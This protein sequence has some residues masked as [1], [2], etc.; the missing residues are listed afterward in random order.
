MMKLKLFVYLL[1]GYFAS[2]NF[3]ALAQDEGLY[4]APPPADAAFVRIVH[5]APD[6]ESINIVVGDTSFPEIDFGQATDHYIVIQGKRK[7]SLGQLEQ[8]IEI[9]AGKLYTLAITSSEGNVVLTLVEDTIISNRTKALLSL[10]NFS[11]LEKVS[12]KT[13]DGSV[14]ILLD[15]VPLQTGNIEVNGINIDLATFADGPIEVFEG[16]GLE[17]GKTY[18]VIVMDGPT[19]AQAILTITKIA[20]E[21]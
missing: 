5:A 17:R 21:E 15:I 3:C 19:S 18:S 9:A 7:A 11:S 4:P 2:L 16:V 13:A 12:L 8:E 1:I 20:A 10:Y 6:V 14:D